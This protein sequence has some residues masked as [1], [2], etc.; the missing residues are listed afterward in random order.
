[1]AH[2]LFTWELGEGLGH[3]RPIQLAAERLIQRG[4]RV[5]LA[6]RELRN[7]DGLLAAGVQLLQAPYLQGGVDQQIS[8]TWSFSQL[9]HNCGFA[10]SEYLRPLTAAWL[11]IYRLCRPDIIVF[12]H[13]PTA[14]FAASALD[15]PKLMSGSGFMCPPPGKPFGVYSPQ[16]MDEA[17]A[18]AIDECEDRLREVVNSVADSLG[19]RRIEHI[20]EIYSGCK[21]LLT[22][23][24]PLDHFGPREGADYVGINPVVSGVQPDW[25]DHP[26][27]RIF[28]Y[29][30]PFDLLPA[31]VQ[32]LAT[33]AQPTILYGVGAQYFAGIDAPTI[34]FSSQPVDLKQVSEQCDFAILNGNHDTCLQLLAQG[35]PVLNIPLHRE[36]QLFAERAA[37]T[38]SCLTADRHDLDGIVAAMNRMATDRGLKQQAQAFS[39]ANPL[40]VGGNPLGDT[41]ENLLRD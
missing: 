9:M 4:H 34:R 28:C 15:L 2:I 40:V 25:P 21:Q 39:A 38:G 18:R 23:V 12:D 27:K 26:G 11:N 36:Q 14:L 22:T 35:V 29:L 8:P 41:I 30:K 37:A 19:C 3:L 20:G 24:S 16:R 13:S 1:M 31:L 5:T 17:C 6:A 32:S 7:S 10:H 33:A